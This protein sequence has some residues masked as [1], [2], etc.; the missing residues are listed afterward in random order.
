MADKPVCPLAIGLICGDWDANGGRESGY[1]KKL[2]STLEDAGATVLFYNGG[3]YDTLPE[4]L[5][6]TALSSCR[7]IM[8]AANVPNTFSKERDVKEVHP[9]T[10]FVATKRNNGEY[11]FQELV[12]RA[13][14]L[15]A[16]LVIEFD[17]RAVPYP[18]R[19]FDPLGVVWQD[20]TTD[21]SKLAH[22]LVRRLNELAAFTRQPALQ[23]NQEPLDVPSHDVFFELVR[24]YADVFHALLQPASGVTRFLGN[25][26]FRCERGFPSLRGETQDRIFVSRRNVDKRFIEPAAFVAV[27]ACD[28]GVRYWGPNKP[29]VDTP[30]QVL[31]Y[32]ELPAIRFMLHGHVYVENAPYTKRPVPCGAIE[33][34]DEILALLPDRNTHFAAVNLLGHGCLIMADAPEKFRGLPFI[35]RPT[36]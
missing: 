9:H 19:I 15:K 29:S 10:L 8:W 25:T 23:A 1:M 6:G 5:H 22:A 33:E 16:N 12:N 24:E 4:I 31:L 7:A 11:S 14:G 35:A 30:I 13:L 21:I 36:P 18:A 17:S 34:A 2:K 20:Y 3:A 27:E 32:R 26:S 28:G